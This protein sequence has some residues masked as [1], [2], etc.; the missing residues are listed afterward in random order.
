MSPDVFRYGSGAT[1]AESLSERG[2]NVY[3]FTHRG[4]RNALQPQ[5]STALQT[6]NSLQPQ[7]ALQPQSIDIEDDPLGPMLQP[8][9][10]G[11][12]FD[13]IV[14]HDVPA[15][16]ERATRHSGFRRAHWIGHGLG[17][18]LGLA[19]AAWSGA[20]Q[21]ATVTALCAAVQFDQ[22]RTEVRAMSK[23]LSML[24]AHWHLPSRATARLASPWLDEPGDVPPERLRGVMNH[25][26]A[27]LPVGLVQQL[28]RWMKSGTLCDK[29]GW[30]DYVEGL[31]D[32]QVPLLIGAAGQDL[33]CLPHQATPALEAWGGADK[34]SLPMPPS[35]GHLDPLLAEDADKYVFRPLTAWL[36]ARRKLSWERDG[37]RIRRSA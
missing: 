33:S 6:T 28:R 14:A 12:D 21:L 24:P 22:P 26:V 11:Y 19:W 34:T 4:D 37:E 2:F 32:A 31:A 3:L 13:D 9:S 27:D 30:Y 1:L 35:W 5:S 29:D 25:A 7:S 16:L 8:Q 36:D 17:G 18:Q 20:D 15:A 23:A 10:R